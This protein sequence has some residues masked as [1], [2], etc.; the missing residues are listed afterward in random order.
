MD[1]TGCYLFLQQVKDAEYNDKVQ[2]AQS[3][4]LFKDWPNLSL[5]RISEIFHWA[6][7]PAGE[8]EIS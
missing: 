7:V 8:S 2:L 3:C 6:E 4:K 1:L 5:K